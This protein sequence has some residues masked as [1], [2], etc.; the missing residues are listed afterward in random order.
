MIF[1]FCS[2]PPEHL[3]KVSNVRRFTLAGKMLQ[4]AQSYLFLQRMQP[5]LRSQGDPPIGNAEK[6]GRKSDV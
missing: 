6:N 2:G 5:A 1:C 3:D 4:G